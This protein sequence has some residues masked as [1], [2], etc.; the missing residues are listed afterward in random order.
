MLNAKAVPVPNQKFA[1]VE[2]EERRNASLI[3][4]SSEKN[5]KNIDFP[6]SSS[7]TTIHLGTRNISVENISLP[8]SIFI[9]IS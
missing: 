1:Y 4:K 6:A 7:A 8:S 9:F 5:L 2:M 3:P